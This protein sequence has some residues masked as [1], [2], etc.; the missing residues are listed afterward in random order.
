MGFRVF[1]TTYKD[2]KGRTREAAKWY[3]E[4]RDHHQ[5]VRRLP[6]FTSKAASEEMGRNLVKLVGYFRG[7]G[8]QVDPSLTT[9]L[10]TLPVKTRERLV[11]IGLL[12][13]GRVAAAKALA[14]HLADWSEALSAKGCT[15]RHVE[16]VTA[17]ARKVIDGCG[18]T[19][20]GDVNGSRVL[21]FLND[22]RADTE[23]KRGISAQTF[24]FYVQAIKQFGRWM[25]KDR[26]AIENPVAYL[27]GLNV[28]VDR[29]HDRRALTVEELIRL[30][31]AA[32]NG[33]E[34]RGM[35]GE[36]RALCYWLAAET[37]LRANE[38]RSLTRA[39]FDLDGTR[40]TVTVQAAYSK[41]R[42][43]DVLPLRPALSAAL[44]SFLA[45]KTPDAP[46]FLLPTDR[47]KA[48]ALFKTDLKA[49]N[50]PIRDGAGLVADFHSLRHTFITNLA[51]AGVHPKTAQTLARHSTI[52][53]TMDRYSHSLMGEQAAALDM[54]PD[55]S[56]PTRQAIR[57]TGTEDAQPAEK[58]L[59]FCLAR[60][61]RFGET[62]GGAD[63][64]KAP[65]A[66][67]PPAAAQPVENTG[68]TAEKA[69]NGSAWES[70][71]Q[72]ALFKPSTGFED[73]GPHQRCKHS[74]SF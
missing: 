42:R 29:R 48:S 65:A 38:V 59:A 13:R 74:Q 21:A 51:N 39:S 60:S 30:L 53:L 34:R 64:R 50:V 47:K 3:V 19:H 73:R 4:F 5:T 6:A 45:T 49:A 8:G 44:R 2:A 35:T 68:E 17:R 72:R 52:T 26:R 9:W 69:G 36:E 56:Q 18:F 1:K 43:E 23:A 32:R 37:G 12:D 58:N 27:E 22:L 10:T 40:P 7:S 70:N 11:T 41:H 62:S 63:G 57:A 14:D 61:Q 20:F 54:L 33:P 66:S 28:R 31:D 15:A 55:L 67:E 71:P 46:A 16:L 24:N 25:V